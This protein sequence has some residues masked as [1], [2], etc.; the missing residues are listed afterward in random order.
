M[1]QGLLADDGKRGLLGLPLF[2]TYADGFPAL[3]LLDIQHM[4]SYLVFS[5]VHVDGEKT[6]RK[7]HEYGAPRVGGNS[8]DQDF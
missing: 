6:A 3:H 4:G 5:F 2:P 7:V 8:D 1:L